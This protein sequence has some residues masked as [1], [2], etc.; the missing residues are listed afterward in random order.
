MDDI[1]FLTAEH[2][3]QYLK[4]KHLGCQEIAE[5]VVNAPTPGAAK[6]RANKVPESKQI[7]WDHKTKNTTMLK[8]LYAK[9][10]QCAPFRQALIE[11]GDCIIMEGGRD[12]YWACGLDHRV[13]IT[14]NVSFMPGDNQLGILLAAV[15]QSILKTIREFEDNDQDDDDDD[16]DTESASELMDN[17]APTSQVNQ[18]SQ[19][20]EDKFQTTKATTS[21][22]SSGAGAGD[23]SISGAGA[24]SASTSG[25]GADHDASTSSTAFS[26][27]GTCDAEAEAAAALLSSIGENQLSKLESTTTS[28]TNETSSIQ[29]GLN[30]VSTNN[31][32]TTGEARVHRSGRSRLNTESKSRSN[33]VTN[34]GNK[35]KERKPAHTVQTLDNLWVKQN[36]KNKK[37]KS[38]TPKQTGPLVAESVSMNID[39]PTGPIDNA[40][41]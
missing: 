41:K 12:Q 26:G 5:E 34:Q 35:Q 31:S 4:C 7:E 28:G 3:H 32:G 36:K 8:V 2:G 14:T 29:T 17:V 16:E 40:V 24:G 30:D 9:A 23:Y 11:T 25:A 21:G 1:H 33:S 37:L 27:A 13:A 6:K 18:T 19:Q 20:S 38:A 39:K 15:R 10:E 22:E